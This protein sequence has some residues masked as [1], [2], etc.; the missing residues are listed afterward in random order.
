MQQQPPQP[1]QPSQQQQSF[2]DGKPTLTE[3][4]ADSSVPVDPVETSVHAHAKDA[5]GRVDA[6][7]KLTELPYQSSNQNNHDAEVDASQQQG[8]AGTRG[9][10]DVRRNKDEVAGDVSHNQGNN[11]EEEC[12]SENPVTETNPTSF[13]GIWQT[14]ERHACRIEEQWVHWICPKTG[15]YTSKNK[16]EVDPLRKSVELH[17]HDGKHQG[18]FSED[19]RRLVWN[20]GDVWNLLHGSDVKGGEQQSND[21]LPPAHAIKPHNPNHEDNFCR[22]CF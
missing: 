17:S 13:N 5:G 21:S 6:D 1:P 7:L 19:G 15:K 11:A 16:L 20:D 2:N 10:V 14:S 12:I 4:P 8:V 9:E 22:S 3:D 18:V